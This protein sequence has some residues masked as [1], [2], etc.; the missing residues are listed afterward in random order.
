MNMLRVGVIG[1]GLAGQ[2][3]HAPTLRGTEGMELAC[4]VERG[5]SLARQRYPDVRVVRSLDELLADESIQVCVVATPN[6]THFEL[7]RRC[8]LAG[9]AVVVDKP[10]ATSSREAAELVRLA[11]EQKRLLTVY[12]NRR[13]DGDF[14]T[15]RKLVAE[16]AL[17]RIVE[18]EARYDRYRLT[19]KPNGWAETPAPGS[20]LMFDLAPHLIDQ[21]LQLFGEPHAITAD[22]YLQRDWATVEDA[23]D[24]C[25]HYPRMR[26][27]LR[28]RV[29]AYAPGPHF[30]I[31]GVGG[32]FEKHGMDPQEDILKKATPPGT[33]WPHW[34]EEP[35]EQWG[36][37]SLVDGEWK[38]KMKTEAG[39]YREFYKN[40]RDVITQG[41]A[42]AVTPEQALLTM[43]GID[44]SYRSS[45]ERR[46]VDWK[47]NVA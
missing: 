26:A 18:Y 44:L 5:T 22:T 10:F 24:I 14:L 21:A 11:K 19:P 41:A 27:F 15:V 46:T 36:T 31:H 13:W 40:L 37:L 2:A 33:D 38:K 6:T 42:L 30:M 35:E 20:G 17:G 7:A 23:F 45:R 12:H 34:G 16:N 28:S 1:Y 3:F 25:L 8:L 9:R 39:D 32:T 29:I 4:I 43:R 47:E